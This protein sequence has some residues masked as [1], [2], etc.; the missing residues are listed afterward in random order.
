MS[1]QDKSKAE[2]WNCPGCK[3]KIQKMQL[4]THLK[5]NHSNMVCFMCKACRMEYSDE[6]SLNNHVNKCQGGIVTDKN[7]PVVPVEL[8]NRGQPTVNL[9][10]YDCNICLK[11]FVSELNLDSHKRMVHGEKSQLF[12]FVN[13]TN[14]TAHYVDIT[15]QQTTHKMPNIETPDLP[16]EVSNSECPSDLLEKAHGWNCPHCNVAFGTDYDAMYNH[17]KKTHADQDHAKKSKPKKVC[18]LC[19][20]FFYTSVNLMAHVHDEHVR[21]PLTCECGKQ[22]NKYFALRKHRNSRDCETWN[23]IHAITG[24]PGSQV[25]NKSALSQL[26]SPAV[27]S[28]LAGKAGKLKIQGPES[29]VQQA[30]GFG[31]DPSR[32]KVK[33]M[34]AKC[35][36]VK[37]SK[38]VSVATEKE[39]PISFAPLGSTSK[40]TLPE[41]TNT[42]PPDFLENKLATDAISGIKDSP[43]KTVLLKFPGTANRTMQVTIPSDPNHEATSIV[44]DGN[45]SY[46]LSYKNGSLSVQKIASVINPAPCLSSE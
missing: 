17:V 32:C 15:Y 25:S 27:K 37:A 36:L 7:E 5:E 3:K 43:Q 26:P 23:I 20:A 1:G 13:I 22:F 39:H 16:L 12:P 2:L 45:Q 31:K 28:H 21:T 4:I 29:V 10:F 18:S 6:T 9:Q 44:T 40:N 14:Q 46:L 38:S 35:Q 41:V 42:V 30:T 19:E 24:S 8:E 11:K 34:N 33:V